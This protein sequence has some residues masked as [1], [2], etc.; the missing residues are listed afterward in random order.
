MVK[1]YLVKKYRNKLIG[2]KF[3]QSN[4]LEVK[5]N[6]LRGFLI[7]GAAGINFVTANI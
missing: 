6:Y 1:N 4:S 2:L 7:R 5:I 3:L